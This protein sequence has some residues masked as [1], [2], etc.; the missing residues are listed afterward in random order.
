VAGR[1]W[2]G[3]FRVWASAPG[4]GEQQKIERAEYEVREAI[5]GSAALQ[6][7]DVQVF[8]QGSYRN[9]TNVPRESDVDICVRCNDTFF[10]DMVPPDDNAR[11]LMRKM[12]EAEIAP[13]TYRYEDY[14]NDLEAA[15]VTRF[16][17]AA[18]VRGDKAFT[19]HET[20][21]RVEA[22]VVAA[23]EHRRYVGVDRY[24]HGTYVKGTEFLS[25]SGKRI[26][27]WPQQ[28]YDN[29]VAK[30]ASTRERFK[31]MVRVV[32]NLRNE[33]TDTGVSAAEPIP[34][35]FNECL[36]YNVDNPVFGNAS[37]YAELR[38]VLR[39]L[40]FRTKDLALCQEWGE[41]NELKYLF[42]E[43]QSWT[44]EAGHAFIL[45]AWQYVGF[46]G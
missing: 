12:A 41:V 42:R 20:T 36:V 40:Y 23:F 3:Q 21:R 32:K 29:G 30:N 9:R 14:R 39:Y 38:E 19:V 46:E 7:R 37:Y 2:E 15:L 6:S 25:D 45:A 16:G 34:S 4:L 8:A 5:R 10:Y 31:A 26:I 27:N 33:M 11:P 44:R 13:A 1:D 35:F 24:G 22:D 18:V 17:R 43:S 28:H